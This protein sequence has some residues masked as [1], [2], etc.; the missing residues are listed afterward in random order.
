M[1]L[2]TPRPRVLTKVSLVLSSVNNV[3]NIDIV[4][5]DYTDMMSTPSL[6]TY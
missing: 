4:L 5:V 3:L 6:L 2:T 1:S